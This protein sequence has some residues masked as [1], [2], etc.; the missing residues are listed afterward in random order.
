VAAWPWIRWHD[1]EV[2]VEEGVRRDLGY[3]IPC[4]KIWEHLTPIREVVFIYTVKVEL[5]RH[6]TRYTFI[7]L[8]ISL[9]EML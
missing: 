4:R 3:L 8:H 1:R 9:I 2:R 5:G 7:R 6:V